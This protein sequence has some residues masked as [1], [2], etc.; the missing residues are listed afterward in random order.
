MALALGSLFVSACSDEGGVIRQQAEPRLDPNLVD[1]GEVQLGQRVERT[2]F[3]Q[4]RGQ[5]SF[6]VRSV[7]RGAQFDPGFGFAY[8]ANEAV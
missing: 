2:V 4:N 7:G 6:S 3:I 1:F 5:A 8:E